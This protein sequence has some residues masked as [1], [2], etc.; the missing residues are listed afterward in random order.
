MVGFAVAIVSIAAATGA[1][2]HPGAE[3]QQRWKHRNF[4]VTEGPGKGIVGWRGVH[5]HA[6]AV[7]GTVNGFIE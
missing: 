7:G 1:A 4:S 5:R 2:L 3:T 6:H